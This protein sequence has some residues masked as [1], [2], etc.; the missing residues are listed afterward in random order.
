MPGSGS[1]RL[2]AALLW[3]V[4]GTLAETEIQGHRLAF[5]SAFAEAGLAWQ[6]DLATYLKLLPPHPLFKPNKKLSFKE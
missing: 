4:D 6:W 1:D 3:D 2:P 5:N